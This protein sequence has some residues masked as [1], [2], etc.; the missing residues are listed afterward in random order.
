[1]SF[2]VSFFRH[3]PVGLFKFACLFVCLLSWDY[4]VEGEEKYIVID[5][6]CCFFVFLLT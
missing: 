4:Q 3:R 2:I 1:M 6:F 5:F